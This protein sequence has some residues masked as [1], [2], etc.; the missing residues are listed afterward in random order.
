[1]LTSF[2]QDSEFR[3]T[4]PILISIIPWGLYYWQHVLLQRHVMIYNNG[5]HKEN[6]TFYVFMPT[7]FRHIVLPYIRYA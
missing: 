2:I 5:M 3:S 4:A 6:D 7:A 1:M